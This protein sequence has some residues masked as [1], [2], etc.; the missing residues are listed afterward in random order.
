MELKLIRN[1]GPQ[2]RDIAE[3]MATA[4]RLPVPIKVRVVEPERAKMASP[5]RAE[6]VAAEAMASRPP[7]QARQLRTAAVAV[8]VQTVPELLPV[9]VEQAVAAPAVRGSPVLTGLTCSVVVAVAAVPPL[10]A[11]AAPALSS[12]ASEG[13]P[14]VPVIP[15]RRNTPRAAQRIASSH[16]RTLAHV[17]GKFLRALQRLMR[18]LLVA[19][20]VVDHALVA[21]AAPVA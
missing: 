8:A 15:N 2:A 10:A 14:R 9:Q 21:A 13:A 20:A 7:S 5:L 6:P 17:R 4:I 12:S 18:S 3:A 16:S 19:A 11:M 1:A